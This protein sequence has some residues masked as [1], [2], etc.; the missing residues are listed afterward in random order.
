M[1]PSGEDGRRLDGAVLD[2]QQGRVV[3]E[4][5]FLVV[6]QGPDEPPHGLWCR[7]A[8]GEVSG[9]QLDEALGAEELT[10]R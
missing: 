1:G 10:R 8:G 2:K 4:L 6:E 7:Q 9:H 5:T 3:V